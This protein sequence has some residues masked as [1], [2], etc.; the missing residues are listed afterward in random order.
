MDFDKV[1]AALKNVQ[2]PLC[3]NGR[4]VDKLEKS[5]VW[6]YSAR[7]PGVGDVVVRGVET[8][9]IKIKLAHASVSVDGRPIK[10]DNMKYL[11]LFGQMGYM[12]SVVQLARMRENGMS[13]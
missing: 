13:K 4:K 8:N 2:S 11:D 3:V 9:N 7:V 10:L 6:E 5:D 12:F 1:M